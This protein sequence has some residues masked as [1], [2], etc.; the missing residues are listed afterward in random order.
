MRFL[1]KTYVFVAIAVLAGCGGGSKILKEPQPMQVVQPLAKASDD[2]L[3][4]T[5]DWI[6]VRNNPGTWAKN[7]DWDEYLVRVANRSESAIEI[8]GIAIFDSLGTKLGPEMSRK[9]LV[10]ASK[11]TYKRYEKASTKVMAGRSGIGLFA[12]G[13]AITVVG[14]AAAAAAAYGGIMAGAGGV[15]V[16]GTVASGLVLAGPAIAIGGMVRH[17][18]N[19]AVDEEIK[20]RLTV[21]PISLA[22]GEQRALNVFFPIAPSPSRLEIRYNDQSGEHSLAVDLTEALRGLHLQSLEEAENQPAPESR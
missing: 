22:A 9:A 20:R 4:A 5:L 18:N 15:G 1:A 10:K 3:A 11:E 8:F 16:V 19:R 6:I 14:G 12:T 13:T 17:A 2:Q 7:A 21:L